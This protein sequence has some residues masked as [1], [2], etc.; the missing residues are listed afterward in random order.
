MSKSKKKG[1]IIKWIILAVVLLLIIAGIVISRMVKPASAP[2]GTY[3]SG[4]VKLQDLSKYVTMSGSVDGKSSVS[5]TADPTLKVTTLNVKKGDQVKKGDVLC[6]LDSTSLQE[7]FNSLS[8]SS[9][10]T[11]GAANYSHGINQRN[12]EKAKRDRTNAINQAQQDINDAIAKRDQAYNDYNAKV[13]RYN[14]INQEIDRVYAEMVEASDEEAA[15]TAEAKWEELKAQAAS[16][17]A[18]LNSEHSMLS[19]YDDAV[20]SANR[21]Y[22]T[23]VKNADDALQLAQDTVDQE[24]YEVVDDATTEKLKKLSQQIE[25]CTIVSP[26]DGIIT[27]LNASEGTLPLSSI[28]MTVSDDS[29]LIVRGKVSESDI[30]NIIKG[31]DCEITASA[32]DKETIKGKVERIEMSSNGKEADGTSSGYAVEV[33]FNDERLLLG[34]NANVKIVLDHKNDVLCLPYDAIQTDENDNCYVWKA[35]KT[36][37]NNYKLKKVEI[38]TGFEA[39]YYTEIT[40]GELNEG[41][42]VITGTYNVS[43]GDIVALDI[44]EEE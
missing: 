3:T 10:K 37:G 2:T 22:D 12:L 8:E 19:T 9:S 21:A 1:K 33:S 41:D 14:D 24:Q 30:L 28:I 43:D 26:I 25:E 31:M 17:N 15:K 44:S 23:I 20:T 38:K 39:D 7:E 18:E 5:I 42:I 34:M 35:E 11:Q 32:I 4:T 13:Q 40:S 36:A 29:S 6:I 27:E 16:L